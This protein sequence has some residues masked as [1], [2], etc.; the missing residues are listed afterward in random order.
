M[1]LHF[2]LDDYDLD[3]FIAV[4]STFGADR[5]GYV[6]TP[7][8]DHLIRYHDDPKFQEQYADASYVLLD[9]RFLSHIFRVAKGTSV[10]VCTGS[11]LTAQL[12]A[13]AIAPNDSI[14]LIGGSEEQAALLAQT[15]GLKS[16]HHY[17]P[18]M[19]FIRDS[20]QVDACLDF[21]ETHSPFRF[22]FLAVGAPQQEI[23]AQLLK[24]RG[25][26]RGLALCI[27]ASINFM[28]GREQRAPQW[29]QRLGLEWAYRLASDPRRLARRYLVRG[30][31]VFSLLLQTNI[32]VRPAT[33]KYELTRV[34]EAVLQSRLP[35][36]AEPVAPQAAAEGR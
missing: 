5:F 31:R 35:S 9:S 25:I 10:G 15:H 21:I 13:R 4:A 29:M 14:V 30:P 17:N 22:C 1:S 18:P 11:D 6:V 3:A 12:F 36:G 34:R 16:L 19:G 27:G 23:L 32:V 28:T 8:V 33:Q 2:E 20:K 7:N 24:K 26:A